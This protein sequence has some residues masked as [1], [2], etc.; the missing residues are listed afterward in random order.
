M[1]AKQHCLYRLYLAAPP[2]PGMHG[3]VRAYFRGF[4]FPEAPCRYSRASLCY[5]T[6]R[7]GRHRAKEER[8]NPQ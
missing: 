1:N 3:L 6:W 4:N 2:A 7:A 8:G 5:A